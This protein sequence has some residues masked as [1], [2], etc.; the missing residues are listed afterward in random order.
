MEVVGAA[1]ETLRETV[2]NRNWRQSNPHS[3]YNDE[4][5]VTKI[6]QITCETM[7]REREMHEDLTGAY[8]AVC[9]VTPGAKSTTKKGI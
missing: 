7:A 8:P 5:R 3:T 9:L 2:R 1:V 4:D 6:V